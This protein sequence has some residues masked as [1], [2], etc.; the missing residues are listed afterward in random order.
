MDELINELMEK[1]GLS[2]A[3]ARAAAEVFIEHLKDEK[4]RQKAVALAG[5]AATTAAVNVAVLPHA[6]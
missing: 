5:L 3:Q 1:A 6:H 4:K 2:E